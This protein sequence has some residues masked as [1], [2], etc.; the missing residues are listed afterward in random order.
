VQQEVSLHLPAELVRDGIAELQ[1]RQQPKNKTTDVGPR[2]TG[3]V[4][5]RC[6]RVFVAHAEISAL[7]PKINFK[8]R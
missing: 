6:L 8:L 3:K 1:V 2:N 7:A 4:Q 5:D